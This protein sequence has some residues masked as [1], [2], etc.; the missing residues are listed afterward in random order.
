MRKHLIA[1]LSACLALAFVVSGCGKP[2]SIADEWVTIVPSP[3][4]SHA[5]KVRVEVKVNYPVK[6]FKKKMMLTV[7]P[8][9][10]TAT[11]TLFTE[12]VVYQGEKV[13]DNN[14]VV[15]YKVG[16][17]YSFISAFD[18]N[19]KFLQAD[20]ILK[21][22]A[23]VKDKEYDL[24]YVK[25]GKGIMATSELVNFQA[26]KPA[27]APNNFQRVITEKK[28]AEIRFLIQQSNLRSSEL[29]SE[30]LAELINKIDEAKDAQN[31]EIKGLEISSYA[32]PDGCLKLNE[33]LA[34]RRDK[35]TTKYINRQIKKLKTEVALS[36]KFSAEDWDGFQALM[37]ESEI[38]DK[39]VIL[40]I[41]SMYEDPE[42]REREIKN[43]SAVYK[44]IADEILPQLRRSKMVLSVDVIGKSDEEIKE[45]VQKDSKA[46]SYEELLYAATLYE[47]LDQQISIYN[48]NIERNNMDWRAQNN[49]GVAL[50]KQGK[51]A[52]AERAFAK[53]VELKGDEPIANFNAGLAALANNNL[54]A[55]EECFGK[56]ANVGEG[57]ECAQGA[58]LIKKGEYQKAV[59]VLNGSFSNNEG[60]AKLLVA[61]YNAART[62][63]SQVAKPCAKTYYLLAVVSARVNDSN[64]V[65]ENLKKAIELD[66][67]WKQY[68][69]KDIEFEG[70][71]GNETFQSIVK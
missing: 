67:N 48:Q 39:E 1:G 22:V 66:A 5:S 10:A 53:A 3:L 58:L 46:L 13:T 59:E 34:S 61:D 47:N 64:S 19:E 15:K 2:Q 69:A 60:L 68:A 14:E 32:S 56:S 54:T 55:A 8:A 43:I 57:L 17:P 49:L 20:L 27:V 9:L 24:G 30:A 62:A 33:S 11:D 51:F 38:D 63:L 29:S 70:L 50:Y 6:Y 44:A 37:Q 21:C 18:Y 16:G 4:E 42:E 26:L 65:F 12:E 35:E 45:L 36:N 28:E 41:L 25:I 7:T 71:F 23:K 40:R 31:Q 52:D